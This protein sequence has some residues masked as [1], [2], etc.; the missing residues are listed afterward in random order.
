MAPYVFV[1]DIIP[2]RLVEFLVIISIP[3]RYI[4]LYVWVFFDSFTNQIISLVTLNIF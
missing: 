4:L 3:S 1:M 2:G